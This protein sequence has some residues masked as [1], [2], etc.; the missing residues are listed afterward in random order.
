MPFR[1]PSRSDRSVAGPHRVILSC[2]IVVLTACATGSR[3]PETAS[4]RPLGRDVPVYL[5]TASD[6]GRPLGPVFEDPSDTVSLRDA[7]A[8]VLLHSPD[9][10]AFAWETRAREARALQAGRLSNPVLEV[11]SEDFGA[12]SRSPGGSSAQVVQPQTTLQLSQ[13][14]ELAGKRMARKGLA[15]RDRDLA[16]WDYEA[17]RMDVLTRATHAF[18]DVLYAQEMAALTRQSAQLVREVQEGVVARVSAGLVS[19]IEATKAEVAVAAADV[20]SH[21]SQRLLDASRARLAAQWGRSEAT[22]PGAVGYL[23]DVSDPPPIAALRTR[24]TRNPELARWAVELSQREAALAVERAKRTPDLTLS[25]GYRRFG[26]VGIDAY[27]VG[28]TLPLPLFDRNGGGT[29]EATSRVQKAYE[30]RRAAEARVSAALASAY[31]ALSSAHQE[32]TALRETVLPRSEQIFAAANEGYRLGRFA[33]LDVLD[34]QRTLIGARGQYL[35]AVS[36]HHKAVAEVE[37]LIGAPLVEI[38]Q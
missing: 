35:R 23:S 20:E 3:V 36:D 14:I 32:L 7:I 22:F 6:S 15:A 34:A 12:T 1:L 10:A 21:R 19:P 31:H 33:Y 5:P 2:V 28:V 29:A 4:P 16:A 9:L 18:I 26:L 30:E 24:L 13:L 11:T 37:R 25:A 38:P 17:T 27:V 8:L